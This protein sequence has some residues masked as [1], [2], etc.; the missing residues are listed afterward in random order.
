MWILGYDSLDFEDNFYATLFNV[1][2]IRFIMAMT[3]GEL[4][5]HPD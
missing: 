1:F 2:M 4:N 3:F 5:Y